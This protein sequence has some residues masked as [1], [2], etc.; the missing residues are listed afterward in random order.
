MGKNIFI[1]IDRKM[2]GHSATRYHEHC[3]K[4]QN[5][6]QLSL[7]KDRQ[8]RLKPQLPFKMNAQENL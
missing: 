8:R 5:L 3:S 2:K 7:S 6:I 1:Q 4:S